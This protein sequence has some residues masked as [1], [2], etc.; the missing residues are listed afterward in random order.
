VTVAHLGNDPNPELI[1]TDAGSNDVTI[2]R[3]VIAGGHWTM[4]PV[5][6]LRAGTGPSSVLVSDVNRD[7]VPDLVVTDAGANEVRI[8]FGRP[9]GTFDDR[10]PLIL[11]TGLQPEKS[12]VGDFAGDGKLGLVTLDA[13]SDDMTYYPDLSAADPV[14]QRLS[15]GGLGPIDAAVVDANGA[16]DLV[17]ANYV[18]G[19]IALFGG[20]PDGLHLLGSVDLAGGHPTALAASLGDPLT[21]F[22]AS[23]GEGSAAVVHLED[24]VEPS[25]VLPIETVAFKVPERGEAV[26]LQPLLAAT[27]ELV[28]VA[29]AEG[30]APAGGLGAPAANGVPGPA[31]GQASSTAAGAD[32]GPQAETE[33]SPAGLAQ[34]EEEAAVQRFVLGVDEAA[35]PAIGP[36]GATAPRDPRGGRPASTPARSEPLPAPAPP[37]PR[38]VVRAETDEREEAMGLAVEELVRRGAVLLEAA[39]DPLAPMVLLAALGLAW[40]RRRAHSGER[41]TSVRRAGDVSPPRSANSGD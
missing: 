29:V 23:A 30:E 6:R 11:A 37:E 8:L 2:L 33:T 31:K 40:E 26:S 27:V 13:G 41:G 32:A 20:G 18:D 10:S 22:V 39:E 4:V 1:V 28:P 5:E 3:S 36:D 19:R 17:V 14:A 9:N 12:F 25:P 34:G 15:S 24:L 7:G 38:P 16:S 21:F 35:A